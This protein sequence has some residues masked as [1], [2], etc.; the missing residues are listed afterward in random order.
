MQPVA[1]FGHGFAFLAG[2]LLGYGLHHLATVIG[3][4]SDTEQRGG[5]HAKLLKPE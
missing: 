3:A 5:F 1:V 2:H 4:I